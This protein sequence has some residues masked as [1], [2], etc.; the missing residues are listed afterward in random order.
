M[1]TTLHLPPVWL[2]RQVQIHTLLLRQP[3]HLKGLKHGGAN[4]KVME[5]MRDIRS[6]VKHWDDEDEVRA[7]LREK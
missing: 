5:M 6:H 4:I 3:C 2:H 1:E 7:Y